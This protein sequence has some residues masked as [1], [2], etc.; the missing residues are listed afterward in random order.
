MTRAAQDYDSNKSSYNNVGNGLF[1]QTLINYLSNMST[2]L[3]YYYVHQNFIFSAYDF[4]NPSG[5][6][7]HMLAC[8]VP[9]N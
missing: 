5:I 9:V 1:A 7:Q 6:F 8:N 4:M 2:H 3:F